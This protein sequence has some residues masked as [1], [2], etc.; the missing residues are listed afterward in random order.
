MPSSVSDYISLL[1]HFLLNI[2]LLF[3]A[4]I[5]GIT[6]IL[7]HHDLALLAHMF[8][9][10]YIFYTVTV[11][12]YIYCMILLYSDLSPTLLTEVAQQGNIVAH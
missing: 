11:L 6:H 1:S 5:T 2:I 10:V 7:P 9:F 3:I 12:V 8:F 4:N